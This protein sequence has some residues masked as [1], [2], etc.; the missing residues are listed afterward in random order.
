MLVHERAR[1]LTDL[2]PPPVP[3]DRSVTSERSLAAHNRMRVMQKIGTTMTN[4]REV[5]KQQKTLD[6]LRWLVICSEDVL[7][8]RE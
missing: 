1:S 7:G 2:F 3:S 6:T 8:S 4:E 5:M